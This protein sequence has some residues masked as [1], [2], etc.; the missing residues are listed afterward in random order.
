MSETVEEVNKRILS[1]EIKLREELQEKYNQLE[2]VSYEFL[3]FSV[4]SAQEHNIVL[5]MALL[6]LRDCVNLANR[7][8]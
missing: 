1:K 3:T 7:I 8:S 5:K 4:I 2:R 6:T